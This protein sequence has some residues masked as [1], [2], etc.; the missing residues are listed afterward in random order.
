MAQNMEFLTANIINTTTM[1]AVNVNTG[2]VSGLIDRKSALKW[3]SD[4][5]SADVVVT[6]PGTQSVDR[7]IIQN[8]NMKNF[9]LIYD[10][11][12]TFVLTS[13]SGTTA[14]EWN[15][16]SAT[17]LYLVVTS[18]TAATGIEIVCVSTTSGDDAYIGELWVCGQLYRLT[19]NPSY[20]YYK[21]NLKA[22]EIVHEMSDG[23]STLYRINNSYQAGID[24][25]WQTQTAVTAL[26][27]IY[28]MDAS[29]VFVPFPDEVIGS[30]EGED[31]F[32]VN[33][34]GDWT[35]KEPAGNVPGY[36]G[37]NGSIKLVEVP[38]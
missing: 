24:L 36:H 22:K 15:T 17:S 4:S 8:T 38:K 1:I 29:V 35:F 10:G 34:A 7:I 28:D 2:S 23:G 6:F 27:A 26:K 16:N 25:K 21:P 5:S 9:D 3:S 11:G 37:Y 19:E 31:I 33:W 12:A 20:Q 13:T 32:L 30:W 18:A 14:S